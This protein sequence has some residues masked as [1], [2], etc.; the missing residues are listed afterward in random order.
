VPEVAVY[1]RATNNPIFSRDLPGSCFDL[2]ISNDGQRVVAGAKSVHAN[3]SGNGGRVELCDMGD[4]DFALRSVPHLGANV[5]LNLYGLANKNAVVARSLAELRTPTVFPGVGTLYIR[6][7]TLNF[8]QLGVT[9]PSGFV[10]GN[11]QFPTDPG[12]IGTSLYF[13]G[14][15]TF[16]RRLTKDWLKATIV[17]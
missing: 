1:D 14:M 2:E 11:F 16:P 4:E 9:D 12:L 10:A 8:F 3:V 7:N 5:V 17:P 15:T 6:R 13:Q